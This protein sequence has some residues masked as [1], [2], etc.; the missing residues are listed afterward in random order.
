MLTKQTITS[1]SR[2]IDSESQLLFPSGFMWGAATAAHQVEGQNLNNDWWAWEQ[3]GGKI[4]DGDSS[5]VACDWW[6]G[7]YQGDFERAS[8]LGQ[9]S[10]RLSVEWSRLEPREGEW[11]VQALH[12]YREMLCALRRQGITPMVTL[13]HFTNPAWLSAQG[14]WENSAVVDQFS[15]FAA[16]VVEGLG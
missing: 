4:K 8:A 6:N 5:L 14:G 12:V 15:R 13:H 10:H 9:N 11:D 2:A 1:T 16:H 7:R 3:T